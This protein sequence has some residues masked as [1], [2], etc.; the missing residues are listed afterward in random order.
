MATSTCPGCKAPLK[1]ATRFCPNCG[2]QAV[3]R[4]SDD[5]R[6]AVKAIAMIFGGV[7]LVLI[8]GGAFLQSGF[9]GNAD[10]FFG[11]LF[12]TFGIILCGV[13]ALPVLGQGAVANSLAKNCR[14]KDLVTGLLVGVV[15]FGISWTY[16]KILFQL[17]FDG[18]PVIQ[19][20]PS[21][22]LLFVTTVIF[23]SLS[24]EWVCRGVL[25]S[26]VRRIASPSATIFCTATLFAFMH[27]LGGGFIFE[28][29]H[30]FVVGLFLGW[31]RN[32]SESLWPGIAGHALLNT[33]AITI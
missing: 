20:E 18:E 11:H 13:I 14:G 12:L 30:R 29:P 1:R 24:E 9:A 21:L 7:L 10:Y 5:A 31:V 27:G 23:P 22:V 16:V 4:S 6:R 32:R 17:G 15:G 28:I 3:D 25:W 19:F 2:Y 8:L 33:L 26:A